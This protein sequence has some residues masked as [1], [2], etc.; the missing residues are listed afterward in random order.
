MSTFMT[1]ERSSELHFIVSIPSEISAYIKRK[2]M[3]DVVH[4]ECYRFRRREECLALDI[5]TFL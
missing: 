2:N 4:V 3:Y 5:I 1:D